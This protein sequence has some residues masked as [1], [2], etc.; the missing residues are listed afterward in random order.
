MNH[1]EKITL[2]HDDHLKEVR[3][4]IWTDDEDLGWVFIDLEFHERVDERA[5]DVLVSDSMA[6][7]RSVD[8]HM[9]L[10]S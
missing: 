4:A 8:V 6:T 3:R 7:S 1:F 5:L 9:Q 10:L 2:L